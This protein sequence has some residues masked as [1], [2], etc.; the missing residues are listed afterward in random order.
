MPDG[1]TCGALQALPARAHRQD[2]ATAKIIYQAQTLRRA[3]GRRAAHAF[4]IAR[5]VPAALALRVLGASDQQL[6]R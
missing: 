2:H 1:S 6:R 3:F 5:R 4:L